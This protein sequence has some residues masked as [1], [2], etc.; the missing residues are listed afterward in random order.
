MRPFSTQ[1]IILRR[2]NYGEA[3][4]VLSLLTP[5][6]GKIS[7]IAKGV[8][9]PKSKLAGG[10]ELFALCEITLIE[11]RGDL[12]LVTSARLKEFWGNILTDYGRMQCAY[13]TIK[14]INQ[15]TETVGEPEFFYLLRDSLGWLN[16]LAFDW[17]LSE[18]VFCLRLSQLLGRGL[19]LLTDQAGQ[20]LVADGRYHY[21]FT[22]NVFYADDH[23]RFTS[24]HIKLLRLASVKNP[25]ILRQVSGVEPVIDDCLWLV[26]TAEH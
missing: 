19:N 13:E 5:E 8:R 26:R 6:R 15:A 7:A 24:E 17:R 21:D 12:A 25:D 3:D 11:G 22:E 2:T 18:L 4:R 14:R 23:G 16:T 1:A 10:L 20:K 9:K